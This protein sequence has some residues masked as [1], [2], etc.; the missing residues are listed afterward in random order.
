MTSTRKK[1]LIAGIGLVGAISYLAIAGAKSGWV[2][3]IDVDQ[4]VTDPQ[5]A[6]QRVRLHGKVGEESFSSAGIDAR[7]LL[8]GKAKQVRVEYHGVIPEMFQAGK[9]VVVEGRLD[10]SGSF[11]A[12]VLMTKCASKYEPESPHQAAAG[13]DAKESS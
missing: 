7:F 5:Y 1:L 9:D 2:Y 8:L 13:A 10:A 3:F 6:N 11:K 4:F 12:D